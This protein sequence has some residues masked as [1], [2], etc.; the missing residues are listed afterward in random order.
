MIHRLEDQIM[1]DNVTKGDDEI[2]NPVAEAGTDAGVQAS[3]SFLD[4]I[5]N[6]SAQQA[7]GSLSEK[8]TNPVEAPNRDG[9]IINQLPKLDMDGE[10]NQLPNGKPNDGR[11]INDKDLPPNGEGKIINGNDR[12]SDLIKNPFAKK[13]GVTELKTGDYL[14]R[15]DGNETLFT[16]NGDSVTVNK[17]GSMEVKGDV[18]EVKKDKN[19]DTTITFKD[20]STVKV[21]KEG[22]AS[23]SRNG[24][25][26]SFPRMHKIFDN[27]KPWPHPSPRPGDNFPKPVPRP[28]GEDSGTKPPMPD[29]GRELPRPGN[30]GGG[31]GGGKVLPD[32]EIRK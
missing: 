5:R 11:V 27:Q 6:D 15:K 13:D 12:I 7:T 31:K 24:E 25:T 8:S 9:S 17:D 3:N 21:D 1:A 2:K 22:I 16:P 4:E 10:K 30:G 29:P 19:G 26:V 32:F 20:G 28:G 18:K 23:V 14:V